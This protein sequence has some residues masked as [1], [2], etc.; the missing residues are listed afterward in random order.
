LVDIDNN[1]RLN[2]ILTDQLGRNRTYA[3]PSNWTTDIAAHGPAGFQKLSLETLLNQSAAPN[4]TGGAAKA[5]QDLG[6]NSSR[7]MRLEVQFLGDSISGAIDNLV[8]SVPEPG[9]IVLVLV[10][11]AFL[12]VAAKTRG[13]RVAI[14]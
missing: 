13:G 7:V 11:T 10:G 9:S 8:F 14:P 1:V 6:F 2:V 5:T 3:V 4:A 12:M